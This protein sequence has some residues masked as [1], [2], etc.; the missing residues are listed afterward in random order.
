[1]KEKT[2]RLPRIKVADNL[3]R[4]GNSYHFRRGDYEESLGT[5]PN[6]KKAIE[7]KE[8]YEKLRDR[9]GTE[10]FNFRVKDLWYDYQNER[11]D[12]WL[13]PIEGRR[14]IRSKTYNEIVY[15]WERHLCKF[16]ASKKL[17]EIDAV[18]W[19]QYCKKSKVSD[20]TN[21]RKVM[22]G[23]LRWCELNGKIRYIPTMTI[24]HVVRRKRKRI[25]AEHIKLLI[26]NAPEHGLIFICQYLFMLMRRA[27]QVRAKWSDYNF[28][29]NWVL[30]P[31]ENVKTTTGRVIPL[32]HYVKD[33]L[34][35]HKK[36]Q[37]DQGIKTEFIFP[38]RWNPKKHI[39][40]SGIGR[41]WS[42]CLKASGLEKYGYEPHDL[43]ATGEHE[44]SKDTRFT[45][46]QREKMAGASMQTQKRI[47]LQGFI[48][49]D[50][51]GLEE[52]VQ[53]EGLDELINTKLLEA[54]LDNRPGKTRENGKGKSDVDNV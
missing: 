6:D 32:N 19:N 1:M 43:R 7:Y 12:Q 22:G 51:R 38:G 14:P 8:L 23:F 34:L 5:F 16:F 39:T 11:K 33:L 42:E 29:E 3:F 53:I 10:A 15:T 25:P 2:K 37:I 31:D 18:L 46:T 48:A 49:D 35:R 26:K 21:H 30:I 9:L 47:Y 17:S 36:S 24:P 41:F 27:E 28:K 13:N 52:V 44:A 20:L 45:D 40:E 50:L 54:P 4:V